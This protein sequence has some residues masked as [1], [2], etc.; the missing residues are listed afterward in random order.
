MPSW[1]EY[2][3]RDQVWY[4]KLRWQ[5]KSWHQPELL[6]PVFDGG[7]RGYRGG[8]PFQLRL[9]SLCLEIV[10]NEAGWSPESWESS[11]TYM[12]G[13]LC[14]GSSG[15]HP[16]NAKGDASCLTRRAGLWEAE[17]TA[18]DW[19]L[20]MQKRQEHPYADLRPQALLPGQVTPPIK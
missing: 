4:L 11:C 5:I 18:T 13:H 2:N 14:G 7:A 15:Q 6:T 12:I 1:L 20:L 10:T 9:S 16:C 3:E 17:A 8:A 19:P